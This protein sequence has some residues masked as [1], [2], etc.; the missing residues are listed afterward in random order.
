MQVERLTPH[1]GARVSGIDLRK[2]RRSQ[3]DELRDLLDDNLV[4][5]FVGQ[6]LSIDEYQNFGEVIGD[7]EVTPISPG[8]RGAG[9]PIHVIESPPGTRRGR[10]ADR[11]HTDVPFV[12]VPPY[13][14]ILMPQVLPPNGG[15]TN[16][17][18]MY[19]AYEMLADPLKRLADELY[20][21]Q[22]I[23][24]AQFT[25]EYVHPLVRLHPKTGRRGLFINGIFSS[26]IV[27]VSVEESNW[28]KDMFMAL[29]TQPD[30]QVRY[31]WT[32]DTVTI[33]DNRFSQ[34]Y[35]CKDY[36]QPRR[37]LRMTVKGEPVV[38]L[39]PAS[40]TPKRDAIPFEK[41]RA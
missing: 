40:E 35:A 13:A 29:T 26:D 9:D 17:A 12:E 18:S 10:Y 4:V 24:T 11:W 3:R 1:I 6:S 25:G 37:M 20:V 27:G 22:S 5:F 34:H 15:D 36:D 28:L 41:K 38:G 19:A 23:T 33:W 14:T 2:V 7:L 31:R 16:W 30:L 39:R 32:P 21:V 8:F